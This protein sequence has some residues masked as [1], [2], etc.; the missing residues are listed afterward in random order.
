M[1]RQFLPTNEFKMARNVLAVVCA[2]SDLCPKRPSS[3]TTVRGD[4][5]AI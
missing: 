1:D 3:E 5:C 4:W 2:E